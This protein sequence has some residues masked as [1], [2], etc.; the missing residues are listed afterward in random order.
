MVDSFVF[1]ISVGDSLLCGTLCSSDPD[2][3][4]PPVHKAAVQ[5]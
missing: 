3:V 1:C 2:M 5:I 4:N